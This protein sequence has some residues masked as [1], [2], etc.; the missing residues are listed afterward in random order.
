[1]EK[2]VVG[3]GNVVVKGLAW[4]VRGITEASCCTISGQ[5]RGNEW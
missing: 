4:A 2:T 1:M 3:G 5:V